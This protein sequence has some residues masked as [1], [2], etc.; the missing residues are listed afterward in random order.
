MGLIWISGFVTGVGI[1]IMAVAIIVWRV[2]KSTTKERSND[3][4]KQ[5]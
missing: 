1:T 3:H 4:A 5:D 2:Y